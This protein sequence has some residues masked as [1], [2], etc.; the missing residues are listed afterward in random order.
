MASCSA[1][2][3]YFFFAVLGGPRNGFSWVLLFAPRTS[4]P[5]YISRLLVWVCIRLAPSCVCR[6]DAVR[7]RYRNSFAASVV[8]A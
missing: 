8:L 7:G 4:V 6:N 1:R 3:S 5:M 2:F